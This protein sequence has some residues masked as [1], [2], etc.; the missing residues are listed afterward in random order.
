[1]ADCLL[2]HE[3]GLRGGPA[4]PRPGKTSQPKAKCGG[5]SVML[6]IEQGKFAIK[7]ASIRNAGNNNEG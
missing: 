1:V 7:P 4:R 3:T 5:A 2:T 6:D